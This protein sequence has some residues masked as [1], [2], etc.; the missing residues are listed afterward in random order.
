MLTSLELIALGFLMLLVGG[1]A[2]L[3]GAVGMATL[4]RLTPAVIGLT[5]VAAGT[6][7]P[8]LA[9]SG[10]AAL[11]GSN[12]IA[13]ANVVG[14]NIFNI[15]LCLGS[16]ALAGGVGSPLSAIA[17]DVSALIG[18]TILAAFFMRSA[19]TLSRAE[20]AVLATV[21]LVFVGYLLTA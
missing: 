7:V 20:G 19:R 13:V 10:V 9:V 18:M 21:Y 5:V 1:E 16:A 4:L 11:R 17:I 3:R 12:E 6:S 2:L 8:E 15:L 14:S